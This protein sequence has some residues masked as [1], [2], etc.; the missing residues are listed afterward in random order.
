LW[1]WAFSIYFFISAGYTLLSFLLIRAG[2][3]GLNAAQQAYFHNL[4]YFDYGLSLL[5]SLCNLS[6]A[7]ALLLLRRIA[8]YLFLTGLVASFQLLTWHTFTKGWLA[9][10]GGPGLIGA[11]IGWGL[12]III[13]LYSWKLFKLGVLR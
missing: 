9:A 8:P 2:I 13:C 5:V 4:T 11:V 6:G 7:I 1:L 10:I 3:I 12:L